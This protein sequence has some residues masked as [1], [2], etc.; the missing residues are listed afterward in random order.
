M[1]ASTS[2]LCKLFHLLLC[3]KLRTV[4]SA[5]R[6]II[7]QIKVLIDL[8]RPTSLSEHPSPLPPPRLVHLI[9]STL[10]HKTG[11]IICPS[12]KSK[13]GLIT[14]YVGLISAALERYVRQEK[15]TASVT[16]IP[17]VWCWAST[18]ITA[19]NKDTLVFAR[20]C[21]AKATFSSPQYC[22]FP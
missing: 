5:A 2:I 9:S 21:F 3:H 18:V 17:S 12:T 16:N 13:C 4:Y 7:V 22:G 11:N 6:R 1:N 19:C 10:M 20:K 8:L 15:C 14:L